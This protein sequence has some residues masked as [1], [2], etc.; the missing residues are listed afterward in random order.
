[1][2]SPSEALGRAATLPARPQPRPCAELPRGVL[3]LRSRL[4]GGMSDADQG[5]QAGHL[6]EARAQRGRHG[7][8]GG[9]D[10][11]PD[12]PDQRADG[13]P[14][15]ASEGSPLAPRSAQARRPAAPDAGLS[16][17]QESRGLPCPDQGAGP[18]A[19]EMYAVPGERLAPG[20]YWG[21]EV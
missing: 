13:S 18:E 16:P 12:D 1:M 9:A 17:A 11:P 10:R 19:L 20:S 3:G 21:V 4:P 7:L 15:D 5:S 14:A 8:A 6:Q 2:T